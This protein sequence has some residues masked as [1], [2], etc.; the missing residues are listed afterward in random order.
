MTRGTCKILPKEFLRRPVKRKVIK[1]CGRVLN[2]VLNL[3]FLI[4]RNTTQV[5]RIQINLYQ[6]GRFLHLN[7]NKNCN[8]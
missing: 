6:K 2:I 1:P 4:C 3:I 7:V 5:F 8:T